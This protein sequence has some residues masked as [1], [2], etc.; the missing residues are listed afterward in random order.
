MQVRDG[1][2]TYDLDWPKCAEYVGETEPL[3]VHVVETGE[4]TVLFG[5]GDETTADEL[6]SIANRHDVDVLVV[7]H[8][9]P[10]HYEGV[11][12]LR[13]ALDLT[14]A[15]PAGDVK[16]LTA[17][18]ITPDHH[19]RNG[20]TYLGI[21]TVS[22]P[23]HTPDNMSYRYGDVVVAG[24]T[25]LGADSVYAVDYDWQGPLGVITP[26]WNVDDEKMR[27]SARDLRTFDCETLLLSHG[28]NV[29]TG[30]ADA[31]ETLAAD[32][33]ALDRQR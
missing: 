31:L 26:D 25:V 18:G 2:Y 15:V 8:G 24:D 7:E 16:R 33:D 6:V 32:L 13:D 27:Q 3:S 20:E 29:L 9:D 1:I 28:E 11:P 23:G 5:A 30:A 4:A 10:D 12:L 19:L 17:E 14:V 22:S 21:R